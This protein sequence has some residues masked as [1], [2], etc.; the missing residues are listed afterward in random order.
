[1][2]C[3]LFTSCIL[4]LSQLV[5][6]F[7]LESGQEFFEAVVSVADFRQHFGLLLVENQSVFIVLRT[8]AYSKSSV[9]GHLGA[10]AVA[11][12]LV[13]SGSLRALSS[14]VPAHRLSMSHFPL[15]VQN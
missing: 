2:F 3:C 8:D 1:M 9:V 11:Q 14:S 6:L 15:Y 13:V 10:S 4:H 12:R 5:C 7:Q